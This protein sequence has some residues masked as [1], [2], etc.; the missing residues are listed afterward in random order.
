[1]HRRRHKAFGEWLPR[2]VFAQRRVLLLLLLLSLRSARRAVEGISQPARGRVPSAARARQRRRSA[3]AALPPLL[4][5]LLP[6]HRWRAKVQPLRHPAALCQRL[7]LP[8]GLLEARAT[9]GHGHWGLQGVFT[10]LLSPLTL[11]ARQRAG[12]VRHS[13]GN[14]V[15][16]A[17]FGQSDHDDRMIGPDA[18]AICPGAT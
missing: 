9:A 4:P 15:A 7:Q 14:P 5:P 6:L 2:W 18:A 17:H 3:V 16:E 13:F 10:L 11:P 8:A 1:V 12:H